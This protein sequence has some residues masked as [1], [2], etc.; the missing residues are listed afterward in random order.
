VKGYS[1]RILDQDL[2]AR[3]DVRL[4]IRDE[5]RHAFLM[6]DGTWQTFEEGV[7]VDEVGVVIPAEAVEALAVAIQ[8][9]QGHAS[10][11]DT[12][13]RVLREWLAVERERVDRA[14]K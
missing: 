10:H 12:E 11:A 8:E 6:P 14:L 2:F 3:S 7:R 13:A 5:H 4:A 1:A 9:W